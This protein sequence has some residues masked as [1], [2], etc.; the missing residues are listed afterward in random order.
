MSPIFATCWIRVVFI[1][2]INKSTHFFGFLKANKFSFVKRYRPYHP[3][4]LIRL[5]HPSAMVPKVTPSRCKLTISEAFIIAFAPRS[6][7]FVSNTVILAWVCQNW[8]QKRQNILTLA[9][10]F[11]KGLNAYLDVTV[12]LSATLKHFIAVRYAL[13]LATP[14][15]ATL[16]RPNF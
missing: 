6:S 1:C 8:R 2:Y 5:R 11:S 9:Y 7:V 16:S 14:S 10:H 12:G 3:I 15:L 4:F 13:S